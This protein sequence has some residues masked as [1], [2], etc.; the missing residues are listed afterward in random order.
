MLTSSS[1]VR[2][3][4]LAA[5]LGGTG[6]RI[7]LIERASEAELAQPAY[8]GREIALTQMSAEPD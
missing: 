5:S 8:D 1:W 4:A 2:G 7:I 3:L 6:A